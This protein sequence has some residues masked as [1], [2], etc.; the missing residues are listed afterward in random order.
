MEPT[1]SDAELLELAGEDALEVVKELTLRGRKITT[2]EPYVAKLPCLQALSLS[3]NQLQELRGFY[4]LNALATLNVNANALTSLA[5]IEQCSSLQQLFA[6]NN[7]LRDLAALAGLAN[8]QTVNVFNN[9]ISSL[10]D[11][12]QVANV[13]SIHFMQTCFC[14]ASLSL[15]PC[16]LT[17]PGCPQVLSGLPV[18]R[19]VELGGNPAATVP[20]YKPIMILNLPA[21]EVLDG[22]TLTQLDRDMAEECAAGSAGQT[23]G[24][25]QILV[26]SEET[27]EAADKDAAGDGSQEKHRDRERPWSGS[28]TEGNTYTNTGKPGSAPISQQILSTNL[29]RTAHPLIRPMSGLHRPG[30]AA[31]A[32]RPGT[33]LRPG[34][35][36]GARPGTPGGFTSQLVSD[37]LLNDNPVLLEYMA[38]FVLAEGLAAAQQVRCT[39]HMANATLPY[40]H[41][42][43]QTHSLLFLPALQCTILACGSPNC[44]WH[45]TCCAWHALRV[46]GTSQ[47]AA[48]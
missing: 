29:D 15:L 43:A 6:S 28:R 32:G 7:K 16:F 47:Q 46:L 37:D 42:D 19:D 22:D 39:G 38:K 1:I 35:A 11:C 30:T 23:G 17:N 3:H 13:E 9:S 33:A 40:L 2:F 14:T 4:Q 24:T 26:V 45:A 18:L 31:T 8:L 5:G 21:L 27:T 25:A 41:H 20:D 12:I 10:D 48:S 44:C 36:S 34:T